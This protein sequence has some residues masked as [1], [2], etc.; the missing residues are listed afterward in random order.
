MPLDVEAEDVLSARLGLV[1]RGGELDPA[2]LAATAGLD[3]G[4]DDDGGA[5]LA[6]G[7]MCRIG[8]GAHFTGG[9]RDSMRV[10]EVL[11]LVLVKVHGSLRLCP[12]GLRRREPT[13]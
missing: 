12:A 9:D 1:G 11:G 3:L 8:G 6:R 13:D 2:C 7:F 10:E 5:D 4:L